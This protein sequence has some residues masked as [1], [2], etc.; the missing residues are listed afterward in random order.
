[1]PRSLRSAPNSLVGRDSCSYKYY[2]L[3]P[4]GLVEAGMGIM[5]YL[6]VLIHIG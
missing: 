4:K 3:I 5:I 1:M 2:R 6:V